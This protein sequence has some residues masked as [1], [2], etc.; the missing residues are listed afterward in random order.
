MEKHYILIGYGDV[1][2]SIASVLENAH[3]HFVVIDM[4]EAKLKDRGFNY[5]VGNGTDEVILIRAGL[6]VA[7]T[8]IIVLNNDDDIIFAT[9]IARNINPHCIIL[10]RANTT[11]SIDKIYRAGADY[12]ASLSN[13]AGQMLA[14]IAIGP[15]EESILML[16]G[17]KIGKHRITADSHLAGISIADA[18]IRSKIGCT[19]IGIEENGRTTTDI[20]PSII[21]REG[22]NLAIIGNSE[23]ISKF[24]KDYSV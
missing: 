20:D 6:K 2:R 15:K 7:S 13:V 24:K 22:M 12:V 4:K 1:G 17:L 16:E 23:H 9:L 3:V 10:T 18:G 21:L 8:V 19:I 14:H 5:Y 11:K